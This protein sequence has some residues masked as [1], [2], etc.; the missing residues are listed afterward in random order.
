MLGD[1]RLDFVVRQRDGGGQ[2]A[3]REVARRP[4]EL[5]VVLRD[6]GRRLD[7]RTRIGEYLQRVERRHVVGEAGL[8]GHERRL[9]PREEMRA[10]HLLVADLGRLGDVEHLLGRDDVDRFDE[11]IALRRALLVPGLV[12]LLRLRQ[13]R[14]R[15][16]L[17]FMV[18]RRVDGRADERGA[19]E[20]GQD[21]ADEPANRDATVVEEGVALAVGLDRRFDAEIDDKGMAAGV[22]A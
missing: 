3:R 6:L 4:G 7:R 21:R 14:C 20:P 5:G 19:H 18:E 17:R 1:L 10:H 9:D 13:R 12:L 22:W 2:R 8:G 11:S 16:E 15:G